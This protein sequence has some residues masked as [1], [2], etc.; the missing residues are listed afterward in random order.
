MKIS[1][2]RQFID[3][4]DINNLI[5]AAKADMITQGMY[6]QKFE[7]ILCKTF[8]AKY[9]VAVNNG[10]SALYLAIKS[11]K[12]KYKSK[13][14]LSPN[15]FFSSAYTIL[16]NDLL[17]DFS[18]IDNQT[19]NLDLNKLES[20]L[21]KDKS[22]KA[23]IAVD[24]AGHP[25]DWNS[26]KFL[27]QKYN[28]KLINDNCHAMGSKINND[29]GYAVKYADLV[30]QSYH[31]TKNFTTGE[32]GSV[33]TQNKKLFKIIE[34]YRNHGI[35]R[36]KKLSREVGK[37][38]YKVTDYGFNFRISDILCALGESQ[39][40]KL[41]KFVIKKNLIA[42]IYNSQF[43][44]CDF[45]ET[46]KILKNYFHSY[47]LYPLKIDFKKIG[48]SKKIFFT[49]M[50]KDGINLQVHYIPVHTQPFL[51]QYGFKFGMYPVSEDFYQKEVSLPI[52]YSLDKKKLD[53]IITAV[54]KNLKIN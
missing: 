42:K 6:V 37:W 20:K 21:K 26:L 14:L 15:T 31:P 52:Y 49:K 36:N 27:K 45:L 12:L 19:N 29:I 3:R 9:S 51:R 11:L 17:P 39:I 53:Y 32:G 16:M 2:G 50:Q 41:E 28:L 7:D 22:I 18:D 24:Y 43:S 44:N 8:E 13:V 5:K 48:I 54:K 35:I 38:F 40:K 10:T 30:T 46:P 23:I 25:C 33:L 34:N 47:H 4:S 1:Y